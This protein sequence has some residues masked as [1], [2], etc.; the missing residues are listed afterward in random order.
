MNKSTKNKLN[1]QEQGAALLLSVVLIMSISLIICLGL[2]SLTFNGLI[3]ARNKIKSAESYYAAEAGLEDSFIRLKNN[4]QFFSS[5][6]LIVG[7]NST[8]IEIS[9]IIG[10]SRTIT[11]QG[12]AQERIKKLSVDYVT[13]FNEVSFYY[14]AQAGEGGIIMS[15]GSRIEGNVFSNGNIIGNGEITD[16]VIVANDGN[17]IDSVSIGGDAHAYSCADC[18]IDGTL[19]YVS[20]GSVGNCDYS[21][22][23][24]IDS[25]ESQAMP[26]SQEQIDDWKSEA[27]AGGTFTGDY[28]IAGSESVSL[29]P[30]RI[31]GNLDIGISSILTITGLVY[32]EGDVSASNNA[33]VQLD[34]SFGS[35][36]GI[37]INDGLITIENNAALSGSGEEDSFLMFLSTNNSL[38]TSNPAIDVS[39][40]ADAAIFYAPNG[41]IL[42]HN[43]INVR[44]ATG[45]Q[46]SLDNNAVISY[47]TGLENVNFTSGPGGSQE[48]RN[49]KEIE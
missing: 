10:G 24:E 12:N 33:I 30:I 41:L 5:N 39:N 15:N 18:D 16:T 26:V 45:Y 31:T 40:N 28:T 11:S 14:G 27:V 49:W 44:E 2:I 7:N 13:A 36:S 4:M 34:E 35:L 22:S 29:G 42:L 6:S 23:I 38:D 25:I 8:D 17:G 21:E 1:K 46:L 20:G 43:N 32:V 9:E 3:S 19:Y 37:I 47:K 48:F